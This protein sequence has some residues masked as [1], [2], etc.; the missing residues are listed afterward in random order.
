MML[1]SEIVIAFYAME[2]NI[3]PRKNRTLLGEASVPV[4]P[5]TRES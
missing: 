5:V 3:M 2:P 1:I 4:L